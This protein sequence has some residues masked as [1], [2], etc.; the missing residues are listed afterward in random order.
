MFYVVC[1]DCRIAGTFCPDCAL[2][3]HGRHGSEFKALEA[4]A[5]A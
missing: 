4:K 3:L 5:D 2:N 1:H